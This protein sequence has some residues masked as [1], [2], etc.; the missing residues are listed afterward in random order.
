MSFLLTFI[1]IKVLPQ[2]IFSVKPSLPYAK[3]FYMYLCYYLS[4]LLVV[5]LLRQIASSL[6]EPLQWLILPLFY[7]SVFF[8]FFGGRVLYPR[9]ALNSQSEL[10][11]LLPLPPEFSEVYLLFICYST[12]RQHRLILIEWRLNKVVK[13]EWGK[14]TMWLDSF[15]RSVRD[16]PSPLNS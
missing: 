12:V 10:T 16:V 13:W 15:C 9:L 14:T 2:L 11:I 7:Y 3:Q 1:P 6:R 4:L 5:Y 8:F